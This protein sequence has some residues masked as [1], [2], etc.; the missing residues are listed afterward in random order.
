M[1]RNLQQ[2]RQTQVAIS[3]ALNDERARAADL[4]KRLSQTTVLLAAA[5]RDREDAD[6]KYR[7]AFDAASL[8]KER[9]VSQLSTEIGGYKSKVQDLQSQITR[10]RTVIDAQT[11]GI[12]E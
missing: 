7:K 9:G 3:Q 12:E 5:T 4:G 8:E 1:L 11:K 2:A 10:Y 6:S